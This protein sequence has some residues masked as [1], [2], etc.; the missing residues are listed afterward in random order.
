MFEYFLNHTYWSDTATKSVPTRSKAPVALEPD[1]DGDDGWQVDEAEAEAGADADGEDEGE[2]VGGERRYDHARWR[3]QCARDGHALATPA[4]H[5]RT[6][7]WTCHR[8][9]EVNNRLSLVLKTTEEV[10][11]F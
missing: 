6:W 7:Y 11:N 5:E 2:H 8:I 1:G 3:E 4:V 9:F 10:K